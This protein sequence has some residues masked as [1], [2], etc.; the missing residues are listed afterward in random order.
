[1]SKSKLPIPRRLTAAV[2]RR[3]APDERDAILAEAASRAEADYRRDPN[4][5]AF[6]AFG[7]NDLHGDSS[8]AQPR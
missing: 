1:M 4:L 5:T 3:L 6:E 8:D 7:E 2:L